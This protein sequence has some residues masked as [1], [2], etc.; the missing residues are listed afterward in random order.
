[1]SINWIIDHSVLFLQEIS[2]EKPR[3][4]TWV[5][6]TPCQTNYTPEGSG[7]A[8]IIRSIGSPN[9]KH[10]ISSYIYSCLQSSRFCSNISTTA[11]L[12]RFSNRTSKPSIKQPSQEPSYFFLIS[13]SQ[14]RNKNNFYD[15]WLKTH[16]CW[17]TRE[18]FSNY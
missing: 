9:E 14:D 1:M 3:R 8:L 6:L 12:S 10:V 4:K 2:L 18:Y 17:A 11:F 16:C 5:V 15:H 13:P 7:G